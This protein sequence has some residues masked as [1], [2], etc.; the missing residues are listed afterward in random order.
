M[1][2]ITPFVFEKN[3]IR[4]VTRDGDPWFVA[5]DVCNALGLENVTMA[6][7]RLDDE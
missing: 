6:L 2:N 3:F 7:K 4:V 5:A 1:S